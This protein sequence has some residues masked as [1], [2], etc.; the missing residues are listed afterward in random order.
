MNPAFG[1]TQIR[2]LTGIF[3]QKSQ[4]VNIYLVPRC[5][6][7]HID[8]S[9]ATV[10]L[11]R[12]RRQMLTTSGW[13]FCHGLAEPHWTLLDLLVRFVPFQELRNYLFLSFAFVS[14]FNYSFDSLDPTKRPS[15]LDLAFRTLFN[16]TKGPGH[17]NKLR[18]LQAFI[19]ILHLIV[20]HCFPCPEQCH[21]CSL[22]PLENGREPTG[23]LFAK[24]YAK[25]RNA[26][27][28]REEGC[29]PR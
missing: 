5:S 25:D 26:A 23:R 6:T 9:C 17:L 7:S 13:M 20:S 14:G 3:W 24:S 18:I 10:G 8:H 27:H 29:S 2:E 16:T 1:P 22:R 19:P 28:C 15:E 21:V 4:E 11:R 12:S